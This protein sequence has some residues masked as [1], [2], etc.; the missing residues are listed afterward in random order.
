MTSITGGSGINASTD[1]SNGVPEASTGT[2]SGCLLC[3][4]LQDE[5]ARPEMTQEV[6]KRIAH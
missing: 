3:L 4:V 1:T 5:R 6:G 2:D